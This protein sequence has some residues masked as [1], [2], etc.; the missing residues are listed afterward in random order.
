MRN[1]EHRN[2]TQTEDGGGAR[3]GGGVSL[4][5][6]TVFFIL[7]CMSA[8]NANKT[9]VYDA[10]G[11]SLMNIIISDI[12]MNVVFSITACFCGPAVLACAQASATARIIPAV[13][14]LIYTIAAIC[15]SALSLEYSVAAHDNKN[16]T[17]VLSSR[18]GGLDS[19]SANTGS[20]LLMIIGYIY[21]SLYAI[22]SFVFLIA[23]CCLA[24]ICCAHHH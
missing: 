18:D 22:T 2:Q 8:Y 6:Y 9:I 4:L 19:P 20:P 17:D 14:A 13:L 1:T 23:T 16:C 10:C 7:A 24:G 11:P 5:A 3:T 12:V 15:L 21:G